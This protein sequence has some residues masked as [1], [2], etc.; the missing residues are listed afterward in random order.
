MKNV[1][2]RHNY[3]NDATMIRPTARWFHKN[4]SRSQA[5][6]LLINEKNEN[7]TFL[8]RNNSTDKDKYTL[9]ILKK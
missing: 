9:S 5:Y 4:L 1:Y 8:I 6:V 7:G 3:D 2:T